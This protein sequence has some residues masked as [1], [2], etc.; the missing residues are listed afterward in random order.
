MSREVVM[1]RLILHVRLQ[2]KESLLM[3][4][5]QFGRA[6]NGCCPLLR[7]CLVCQRNFLFCVR[8]DI[9]TAAGNAAWFLIERRPQAA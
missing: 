7:V 1:C 9:L 4:K 6:L 2:G 3:S 5:R 8:G